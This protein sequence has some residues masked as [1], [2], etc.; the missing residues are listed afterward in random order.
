MDC[1]FRVSAGITTN[2]LWLGGRFNAAKVETN[3]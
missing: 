3:Y 1:H 2:G